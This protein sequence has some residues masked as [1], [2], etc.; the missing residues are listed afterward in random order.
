MRDKSG[1]FT[2]SV[3]RFEEHELTRVLGL[4]DKGIIVEMK[5]YFDDAVNSEIQLS[6]ISSA[7]LCDSSLYLEPETLLVDTVS[8]F[9]RYF[10]ESDSYGTQKFIYNIV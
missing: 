5:L 3:T 9:R 1:N 2:V 7:L 8:F 10:K 6:D 4:K